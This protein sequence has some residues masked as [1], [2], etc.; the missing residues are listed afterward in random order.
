MLEAKTVP[1]ASETTGELNV[2]LH[3]GDAFAV[4][5]AQV[6]VGLRCVAFH[7]VSISVSVSVEASRLTHLQ[8]DE[9]ETPR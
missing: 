4:N 8:T 5:G 6:S 3:D 7:S 9:R 1:S 2:F